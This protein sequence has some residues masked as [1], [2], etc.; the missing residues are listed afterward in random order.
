MGL[1]SKVDLQGAREGIL[2]YCGSGS[3]AMSNTIYRNLVI[4]CRTQQ[5]VR[6][7]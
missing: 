2:D 1:C 6:Y 5:A 3:T 4:Y 7:L